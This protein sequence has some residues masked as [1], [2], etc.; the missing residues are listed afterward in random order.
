MQQAGQLFDLAL[1]IFAIAMV[2]IFCVVLP[3]FFIYVFINKY[4]ESKNENFEQRKY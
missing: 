4:K 3:I 2:T 1:D